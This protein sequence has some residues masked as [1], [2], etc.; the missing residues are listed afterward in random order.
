MPNDTTYYKIIPAYFHNILLLGIKFT[1]VS[2]FLEELKRELNENNSLI[3]TT[4]T[5]VLGKDAV[6][7]EGYKKL[8]TY[9]PVLISYQ[10]LEGLF[11]V[12][13]ENL[14]LKKINPVELLIVG[15]IKSIK[16]DEK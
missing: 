15:K 11:K 6:V 10:T 9:T 3:F 14:K 13:G 5:T 12:E 1:K 8:V 16:L 4:K 2:M 7:I